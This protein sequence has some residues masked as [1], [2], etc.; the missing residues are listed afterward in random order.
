MRKVESQVQEL[1]EQGIPVYSYSRLDT[2]DTCPHAYYLQYIKGE[3][4]KDN[5]WNVLGS[6]THDAL[7]KIVRDNADTSILKKSVKDSLDTLDFIGLDF[8]KSNGDMR[9]NWIN[10]M[11][12]FASHY[13]KPDG[14]FE[15]EK[16]FLLDV[17]GIKIQGYIDLIEHNDDGSVNIYDYKTSS[18]YKGGDIEKHG[19]Q[20]LI[21]AMALEQEG[22]KVNKVAW[23][24]LKYAGKKKGF[25]NGNIKIT[26]VEWRKFEDDSDYQCPYE[27]EYEITEE[28][29][30]EC[31][32]FVK[33]TVE[34]INSME[35][36]GTLDIDNNSFFCSSLC[37]VRDKCQAYQDYCK[38]F[39]KQEDD[40]F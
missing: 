4:S 8:P 2:F 29:K 30:Q 5:V 20:L 24:F 16:F 34:L 32:D 15:C 22:I 7:E 10:N 21:Y 9:G 26:P 12:G 17:D 36:Y 27:L 28:N 1:L 18:L 31:R 23:L 19:R 11:N 33:D 6:A 37:G 38:T 3:K 25:K 35:E 39:V 40:L 13:Q 14:K